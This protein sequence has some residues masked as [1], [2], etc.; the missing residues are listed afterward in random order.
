MLRTRLLLPL[1]IFSMFLVAPTNFSHATTHGN[2]TSETR[3]IL[4][5]TIAGNISPKSVTSSNAGI[6]SAQ[7]MMYRHSITIYDSHT[8]R[9]KAT[10][11]DTVR[12]SSYGYSKNPGLYKGAPVEGAYSPDGKYL[13]VT[14]YSM[15]G[16]SYIREGH[17]VCSPSSHFDSS[18][19]YRI[20]LST[21]AIDNIYPVGVVPKGVAVTPDNSYVLVSNWCSYSLS[22]IRIATGKTV[23]TINVGA[24]PRGIAVSSDSGHAYIAEMGGTQIHVL[25]L[26]DFSM[27]TIPIG[28][29]PRAIVLS[30]DGKKLY[31]S[32]N[33]S[34]RVVSWNLAT[35]KAGKSIQT[36]KDARSLAIS[37]D[38][39]ALFVTNYL[40][41][42]ISKI[43]ASKMTLVQTINVC[44]SPIGITY[45]KPTSRTWVA[46]YDGLIKIFDNK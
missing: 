18:F 39:S 30:P 6:V 2:L 8:F 9:L 42:T 3:L 40:S 4:V 33:Q 13:Y 31:A 34:G 16:A 15:Y 43:R 17:D 32:L 5:K 19:L 24:Y 21:Y 46:C 10:I 27:K 41:G 20:N 38:G 26:H 36:G 22:V 37:A 29:N 14:N 7:N 1:L 28:L 44:K 12:L 25:N 35:N 45:D 23:K 11:P